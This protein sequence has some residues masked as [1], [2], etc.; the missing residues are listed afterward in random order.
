MMAD[1]EQLL[2]CVRYYAAGFSSGASVKTFGGKCYAIAK[3][4]EN[5]WLGSYGSSIAEGIAIDGVTHNDVTSLCQ[6]IPLHDNGA[7]NNIISDYQSVHRSIV[8]EILQSN[9]QH[10]EFKETQDLILTQLGNRDRTNVLRLLRSS[11]GR[12]SKQDQLNRKNILANLWGESLRLLRAFFDICHWMKDSDYNGI[13]ISDINRELYRK[14]I[15]PTIRSQDKRPVLWLGTRHYEEANKRLPAV[16]RTLLPDGTEVQESPFEVPAEHLNRDDID[17]TAHDNPLHMNVLLLKG[18]LIDELKDL[19]MGYAN[20]VSFIPEKAFKPDGNKNRYY[21]ISSNKM[22]SGRTLFSL[23]DGNINLQS[24]DT[25]KNEDALLEK[26][27]KFMI[28]PYNQILEEIRDRVQEE[29]PQR[30]VKFV[31]ARVNLIQTVIERGGNT[32]S[33]H[34][35]LGYENHCP[36]PREDADAEGLGNFAK[37]MPRPYEVVVPT[38]VFVGCENDDDD[39]PLPPNAGHCTLTH[40]L[41]H[42]FQG[43]PDQ[44]KKI[45]EHPGKAGNFD[46][47]VVTDQCCT[48]VQLGCQAHSEHMVSVISNLTYRIWRAI[49]SLRFV[50]DLN[51]IDDTEVVR[52]FNTY[53]RSSITDVND[54]V[55]TARHT[56]INVLSD[57]VDTTVA[58]FANG[59]VDTGAGPQPPPASP[60]GAGTNDGGTSAHSA[61]SK[62]ARRVVNAIHSLVKAPSRW[63][64]CE[65]LPGPSKVKSADQLP[66]FIVR[67]IQAVRKFFALGVYVEWQKKVTSSDFKVSDAAF[68]KQTKQSVKEVKLQRYFQPDGKTPITNPV[69]FLNERYIHGQIYDGEDIMVKECIEQSQHIT[70][71]CNR[72]LDLPGAVVLKDEK[73]NGHWWAQQLFNKM[74]PNGLPDG[75]ED[76]PFHPF[77]AYDMPADFGIP[78]GPRGGN[79]TLQSSYGS[80]NAGAAE[81]SV[82]G[83]TDGRVDIDTYPQF[84]HGHKH[85]SVFA[86]FV[87]VRWF[88]D[89][90]KSQEKKNK[91]IFFGYFFWH[92]F[93]YV[94]DPEKCGV[95]G[96]P[97]LMYHERLYDKNDPGKAWARPKS[98][99][100][101]I[102][103]KPMYDPDNRP[104]EAVLNND[105]LTKK[106]V[107]TGHERVAVRF[108]SM[109]EYHSIEHE[110]IVDQWIDKVLADANPASDST[111]ELLTAVQK[112]K[113]CSVSTPDFVA[114][115][116]R[117]GISAF[118]RY[119][120]DNIHQGMVG[121]LFDKKYAR[122]GELLRSRY[123]ESPNRCMNMVTLTLLLGKLTYHDDGFHRKSFDAGQ[124][125]DVS[126]LKETLF[127]ATVLRCATT[128]GYYVLFNRWME[129]EGQT[130]ET[131]TETDMSNLSRPI[132]EED[133][134]RLPT[135]SEIDSFIEFLAFCSGKGRKGSMAKFTKVLHEAA[136]L[137]A[138]RSTIEN[139]GA[140]LH[141]YKR[142][143]DDMFSMDTLPSTRDSWINSLEAVFKEECGER[144]GKP[145]FIASLVVLDVEEVI[146]DPFGKPDNVWLGHGGKR[147]IALLRLDTDLDDSSRDASDPTADGDVLH[148]KMVCDL[149]LDSLRTS[150]SDNVLLSLGFEKRD[151]GEVYN[152][153]NNAPIDVRHMD[154][155]ICKVSYTESM[156]TGSRLVSVFPALS[157]PYGWPVSDGL[158]KVYNAIPFLR[159][160]AARAV[161]VLDDRCPDSVGTPPIVFGEIPKCFTFEGEAERREE[162]AIALDTILADEEDPVPTGRHKRKLNGAATRNSHPKRGRAGSVD[163][164]QAVTDVDGI[165]SQCDTEPSSHQDS[166]SSSSSS[167]S[168]DSSSETSNSSDSSVSSESSSESSDSGSDSGDGAVGDSDS[169]NND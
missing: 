161:A 86:L 150:T 90:Y 48:H 54:K 84:K 162:L 69:T 132:V 149:L 156:T 42:R 62:A 45:K 38:L 2:E 121:Y 14:R 108:A 138:T 169:E 114:Q 20:D 33:L 1:D 111:G 28:D 41:N 66:Q 30:L 125:H 151:D 18:A 136:L 96:S 22:N 77:A 35:D 119:Q 9:M 12:L 56:H 100:A 15:Q 81:S 52:S 147:G 133:R 89:S 79:G 51:Q 10:A 160:I 123:I 31:P 67:G 153:I 106:F 64:R 139:F 57:P 135:M 85:K 113:Q 94:T 65:E 164:P 80:A 68:A 146:E 6:A 140:F 83:R 19:F 141:R 43:N 117:I 58:G 27:S 23:S 152:L 73:K 144:S 97:P 118:A 159:R 87:P 155:L 105:P 16:I 13:A 8:I 109:S 107:V 154:H 82:I 115:L 167:A 46:S 143:L 102:V 128:A 53:N 4:V 142:R 91:V 163:Q 92:K 63:K 70:D 95:F 93:H 60:N 101:F 21:R 148:H 168:D 7:W 103:C 78:V 157:Q 17:P 39:T 76:K 32:Y 11:K 36:V 112:E 137:E 158:A 29:N 75:T 49:L 130:I 40:H 165:S 166:R 44:K 55:S 50:I 134:V 47:S 26:W 116:G 74:A 98:D 99:N 110:D 129:M 59:N 3:V 88:D 104:P 71:I 145:Y 131:I 34:N 5:T 24:T 37:T 61:L 25:H 120:R 127:Q 126:H 122:L 124:V 72:K